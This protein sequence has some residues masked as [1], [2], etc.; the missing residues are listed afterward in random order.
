MVLIGGIHVICADDG[1]GLDVFHLA[2]LGGHVEVHDVPG[3]VSIEIEDAG[4]L[5]D[6]LGDFKDLLGRRGLEDAAYGASVQKVL[7]DIAEEE[8]KV[9]GAAAGY[10]ADFSGNGIGG[11][12][13]AKIPADALHFSLVRSIDALQHIIGILFRF[14]DDFFH[15]YS[16]P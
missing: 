4:A 7:S 6:T 1:A 14:V 10:D 2:Q 5:V 13:A 16:A 9:A 15:L 3:V 12:I 8:R 11:D